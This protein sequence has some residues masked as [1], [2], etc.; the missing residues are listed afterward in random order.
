[1]RTTID[2]NCDMGEDFGYWR[3][4]DATAEEL[5]PLITSANIAAGFHA[6]D[7]SLMDKM[8]RLA[9]EGNIGV[10]VHPGYRDIVGFGRRRIDGTNTEI[11]NDVIYQIGALQ[12]FLNRYDAKLQHVKPHGALYMEM[13]VNKELAAGLI[14][15]MCHSMPDAYIFCMSGTELYKQAVSAGQPI[16]R[17]FFADRHYGD[18]G[19]I[20]FT[21]DIGRLNLDDISEKVIKAIRDGEVRSVN[22][23]DVMVE[24]DSICFHSDTPGCVEIARAIGEAIKQE[25]C[26]MAPFIQGNGSENLKKKLEVSL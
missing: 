1:M 3:I 18:D 19:Q 15:Y 4:G 5:F 24:F 10:G 20:I 7:P 26:Q 21:R 25:N 9:H 8:V 11:L 23:R 13:A 12:G 14:S 6:G 2:V 17:E 22:G 16:V